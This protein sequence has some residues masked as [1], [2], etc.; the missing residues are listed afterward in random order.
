MQITLLTYGSRGDVQPYLALALGLQHSGHTVRLAAPERFAGLAESFGIPFAALAGDPQ[1]ISA[2]MNDAGTNA[3]RTVRAIQEYVFGIAGQVVRQART[4]LLGADLVVHSFLFT[5]GAHSFARELGIPDV[6]VQTFPIFAPTCAFPNVA[7]AG[8]PVGPLSFLSHWFATQVFWHGGNRGYARLRREAP[9]EFPAQLFWPFRKVDG[10][11]ITPLLIAVS[12]TILPRP[13]EWSTASVHQPG[14]FFLDEPGYAP[15]PSLQ[16]F[17]DAGEAPVCVSFGSMV[18][19]DA[20]RIGHAVLEAL[21]STGR[22]G[23]LLTGWGGWRPDPLPRSVFAVEAAPHGWLLPRCAAVI[24]HG[25]AGTTAAG[26]RA[27]RPNIVVP[28]TADQPFWAGR[29]A[30]LG[31]GPQPLPVRRMDAGR[32]AA[33]IE[34]ALTDEGILRRA[35]QVGAAIRA[36]Q[37]VNLA[38]RLIEAAADSFRQGHVGQATAPGA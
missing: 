26:L 2:R 3:W 10:R 17:L 28:F 31:A 29:I 19:R 32:L 7:L 35:A 27:G 25:G 23:L 1:V 37:G 30:A 11:P 38:V 34:R 9:A 21:A 22:R 15:E 14:S 16:T 24:H 5:T 33:A 8:L 36:E 13:R 18:H 6:S 20:E 12:P 4:A